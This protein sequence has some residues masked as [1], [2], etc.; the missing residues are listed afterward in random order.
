MIKDEMIERIA[1][2]LYYADDEDYSC[3]Q[4]DSYMDR[5]RILALAACAIVGGL[6][7]DKCRDVRDAFYA[8][9]KA[10]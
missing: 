9:D 10:A 1:L 5:Y 7:P 8:K 3:W 6:A 4:D 2:G